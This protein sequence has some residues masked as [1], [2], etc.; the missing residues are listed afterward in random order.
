[1]G[2]GHDPRASQGNGEGNARVSGMAEE[3]EGNVIPT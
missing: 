1:M 2:L 3:M